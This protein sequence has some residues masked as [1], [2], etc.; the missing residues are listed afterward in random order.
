MGFTQQKNRVLVVG[1]GSWGT[2]I[3][4]IAATN[5]RRHGSSFVER[6]VLWVHDEKLGPS[7]EEL[8]S[9][10]I[11]RTH[12]NAKYL[13]EASL[14]ENVVAEPDLAK[15]AHQANLVIFAVP[16][17]FIHTGLFAKILAGCA[18]NTRVLS[19]VKGL[20]FDEGPPKL[21]SSQIRDEMQLDVSVLMGANVAAEVCCCPE[22]SS[23]S[24]VT[25]YAHLNLL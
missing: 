8:L 10:S 16:Q 1:A 9:A 2:A 3:A 4:R 14:P 5:A 20:S 17:Q 6:V 18:P 21:V 15:A 7:E 24:H 23:G 22:N 13:P 12:C 19:L 25:S 11:N